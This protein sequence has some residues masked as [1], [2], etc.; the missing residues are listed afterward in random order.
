MMFGYRPGSVAHRLK[1]PLLVCIAEQYVHTPPK[2][3]RLIAQRAQRGEVL[4]YPCSHFDIYEEPARGTVVADQIR[5][6][7]RALTL[8]PMPPAAGLNGST[9]GT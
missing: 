6:L 7:K 5:F 4:S 1:M 3:A 2:L 8:D 9:D